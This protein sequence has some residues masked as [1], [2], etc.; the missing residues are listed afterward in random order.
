MR[1]VEAGYV[2]EKG[3]YHK[4]SVRTG[5]GDPEQSVIRAAQLHAAARG[6]RVRKVIGT[7]EERVILWEAKHSS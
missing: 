2:D 7:L 5:V 3:V 1:L 4:L 6:H